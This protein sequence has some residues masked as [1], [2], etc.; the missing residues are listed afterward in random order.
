MYASGLYG[1]LIVCVVHLRSSNH[2]AGACPVRN[3][4]I[5]VYV[6][7]C[8]REY[9]SLTLLFCLTA[10][11]VYVC[12]YMCAYVYEFGNACM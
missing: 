5:C 4:N 8:K 9:V 6:N 11:P 3:G 10:S 12:V 1:V 2:P 7:M